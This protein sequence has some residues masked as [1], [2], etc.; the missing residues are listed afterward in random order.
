MFGLIAFHEIAAQRGDGLRPELLKACASSTSGT[1]RAILG[2]R[3][4][5][6]KSKFTPECVG[7]PVVRLK[8]TV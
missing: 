7:D 3:T 2:G 4:E 5:V 6:D 1:L 8:R